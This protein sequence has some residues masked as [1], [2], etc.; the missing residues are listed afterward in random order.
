MIGTAIAQAPISAS[1]YEQGANILAQVVDSV[2]DAE[3]VTVAGGA[4]VMAPVVD[5][6]LNAELARAGGGANIQA[7][8]TDTILDAEDV[9][10]FGFFPNKIQLI[11]KKTDS[12]TIN[13]KTNVTLP[14]GAQVTLYRADSV[15][16]TFSEY[17]TVTL[18]YND[19][20]TA[21]TDYRYKGLISLNDTKGIVSDVR[22][23]KAEEN[24]L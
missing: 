12:T 16:G 5:S 18:A 23:V 17:A 22:I 10:V 24:I 2:L 21:A 9:D 4:N 19:T 6:D 11:C 13:I 15:E 14:V 20:V 1:Q 7:P 8:V 3:D